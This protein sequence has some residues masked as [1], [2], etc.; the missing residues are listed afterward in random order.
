MIRTGTRFSFQSS[1]QLIAALRSAQSTLKERKQ[2]L[3]HLFYQLGDTFRDGDYEKLKAAMEQSLRRFDAVVQNMESVILC[4]TNYREK[5]LQYSLQSAMDALPF[6]PISY[7][8]ESVRF[9]AAGIALEQKNR[10]LEFQN[11]V[12][13]RMMDSAV[14]LAAKQAYAFFGAH[15]SIDN[16]EYTGPS[17]YN[18]YR[19]YIRFHLQEDLNNCWGQLATYFHEVGHAV[20]HCS[21]GDVWLSSDPQFLKNLYGDFDCF[22]SQ[23]MERYGCSLEEAY[24]HIEQKFAENEDLYSDISDITDGL[25][26]GNCHGLFGHSG[27]YWERDPR[28]VSQEAFANMFS[29][30]FG[31]PQRAEVM[32]TFFPTAYN[33]FLQ[34]LEGFDDSH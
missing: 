2:K 11:E 27:G 29:T 17:H 30:A 4:M 15:C 24:W 8:G 31:L 22:L 13:M 18:P 14:P 26:N 25:T 21:G 5:L 9:G 23:T 1:E 20:D 12:R 19:G 3:A 33:R 16:D 32:K 6:E 28:R 10:Q 7:A 34:L